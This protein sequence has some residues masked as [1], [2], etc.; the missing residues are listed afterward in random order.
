MQNDNNDNAKT[1]LYQRINGFT[2][3]LSRTR[4]HWRTKVFAMLLALYTWVKNRGKPKTTVA[5]ISAEWRRMFGLNQYWKIAA[6][7]DGT[8]YGEIHFACSLEGTGDVQ[9]CHRLMEY[10]RALLAKI[11]GQLVVLESRA[12]P[13]VKGCCKVAIRTRDD[14][15]TDLVAA[16]QK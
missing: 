5:D 16:H 15:R 4:H 2:G 1:A 3:P 12:D 13:R 6:I 11:G 8:A 10:D 14:T 7:T 9:A